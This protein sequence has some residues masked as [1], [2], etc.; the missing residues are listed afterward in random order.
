MSGCPL[1]PTCTHIFTNKI[2]LILKNLGAEEMSHR[3]RVRPVPVPTLDRS[4]PP[5]A[6][7]PGDRP[8]GYHDSCTVPR[9]DAHVINIDPL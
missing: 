1:S 6:P 4:Q 9:T 3:L 7:A 2:F 5:V 8:W